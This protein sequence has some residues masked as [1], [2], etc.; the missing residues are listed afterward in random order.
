M[1]NKIS[2]LVKPVA[3]RA[4]LIPADLIFTTSMAGVKIKIVSKTCVVC[5]GGVTTWHILN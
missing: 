2:L 3:G 1:E 4:E 5:A